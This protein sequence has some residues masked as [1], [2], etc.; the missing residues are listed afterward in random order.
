L[1]RAIRPLL[2]KRISSAG[3]WNQTD[4]PMNN[5]RQVF[6]E[7]WLS[8]DVIGDDRQSYIHKAPRR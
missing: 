3:L 1:R 4:K 2:K 6:H 7:M 5:I 8:G